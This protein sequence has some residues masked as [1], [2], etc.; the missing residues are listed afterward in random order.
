MPTEG[1]STNWEVIEI[2]DTEVIVISSSDDGNESP[3]CAPSSARTRNVATQRKALR[4]PEFP[5]AKK[6]R[7]NIAGR[8]LRKQQTEDAKRFARKVK[9]N[10]SKAERAKAERLKAEDEEQEEEETEEKRRERVAGNVRT[11]GPRL[12]LVPSTSTSMIPVGVEYSDRP[13]TPPPP[14][15]ASSSATVPR[16]GRGARSYLIELLTK[17]STFDPD[18]L[19]FSIYEIPSFER[20]SW[21]NLST[22]RYVVV[23]PHYPRSA[24]ACQKRATELKTQLLSLFRLDSWGEQDDSREP[25]ISFPKVEGVNKDFV[26]ITFASQNQHEIGRDPRPPLK[27]GYDALT[28]FIHSAFVDSTKWF[29]LQ[30]AHPSICNSTPILDTQDST[31]SQE[32][33]EAIRKFGIKAANAVARLPIF[34]RIGKPTAIW[35][36]PEGFPHCQDFT[37]TTGAWDKIPQYILLLE[38]NPAQ[39]GT[40]KSGFNLP[41]YLEMVDCKNKDEKIHVKIW[42]DEKPSD[43][44]NYCKDA[45]E[46][47]TTQQC[48][49]GSKTLMNRSDEKETSDVLKSFFFLE[50]I[51]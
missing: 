14:P 36:I 17:L 40:G 4:K 34:Q 3:A 37:P 24:E 25:R 38:R 48:G 18:T 32:T 26:D 47:H 31:S 42:W 45:T 33:R 30:F 49:R 44:C 35:S 21:L 13:P 2:S 1:S 46:G 19:P 23:S 6:D 8:K 5:R 11:S 16:L 27:F 22:H 39:N 51:L 43:L 50:M 10:Q 41:A 7:N 28:P 12:L 20:S 29:V 15:R 9:R